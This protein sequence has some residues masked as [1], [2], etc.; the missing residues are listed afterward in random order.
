[1]AWLRHPSIGRTGGGAGLPQAQKMWRTRGNTNVLIRAVV[2]LAGFAVLACMAVSLLLAGHARRG[3]VQAGAVHTLRRRLVPL[4]RRHAVPRVGR[5]AALVLAPPRAP[6]PPAR[7]AVL[8]GSVTVTPTRASGQPVG[9]T[10]RWTATAAA[11][12]GTAAVYRF[13][14]GA[15]GGEG[16]CGEPW[17]EL[18]GEAMC[19]PYAGR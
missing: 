5:R 11:P 16:G 13:S 18:D 3:A 4:A 15:R 6:L 17:T 2:R 10:V 8:P 1:M 19:Q 9:T 14:V 12:L 7:A